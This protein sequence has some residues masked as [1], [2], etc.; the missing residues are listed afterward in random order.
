ML[1]IITIIILLIIIV[2]LY[3][4]Y[5]KTDIV[6]TSIRTYDNVDKN[7]K[8]SIPFLYSI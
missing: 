1:F 6:V 8:L 5:N 7:N 2:G 4:Y 3:F